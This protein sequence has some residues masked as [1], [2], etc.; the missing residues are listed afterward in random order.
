MEIGREGLGRFWRYRYVLSLYLEYQSEMHL[1]Q[2][3]VHKA[4]NL[5]TSA[6]EQTSTITL[7][8]IRSLS[9]LY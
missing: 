3:A 7:D 6:E 4:L 1:Y 8:L 5:M 9:K 2:H